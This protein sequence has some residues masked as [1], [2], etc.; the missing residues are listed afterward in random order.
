MTLTFLKTVR[1]TIM[2]WRQ[3]WENML[4]EINPGFIPNIRLY[5]FPLISLSSQERPP[6]LRVNGYKDAA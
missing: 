3:L 1:N 6:L 2:H 4:P 5:V